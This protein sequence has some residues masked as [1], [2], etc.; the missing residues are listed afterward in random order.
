[1]KYDI[2]SYTI[3]QRI[4]FNYR[5]VL[6]IYLFWIQAITRTRNDLISVWWTAI[7]H[8]DGFTVDI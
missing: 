3:I 7:I 6:S 2:I 1:M 5:I 8:P 4:M